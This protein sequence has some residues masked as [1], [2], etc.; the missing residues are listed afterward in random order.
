VQEI[1][2]MVHTGCLMNDSSGDNDQLVVSTTPPEL[3]TALE[4][5]GTT[6]IGPRGTVLF[7][8][9][10]KPTGVMLL[11]KGRVR[12]SLRCED[13]ELTY[14][15][16]GPGYLLGLPAIMGDRPYSLTAETLDHCVLSALDKDRMMKLLAERNDLS[17]QAV[18]M[19]ADEVARMRKHL[20]K[21]AAVS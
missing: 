1:W 18:A 16:V 21:T 12:L 15:T 2:R 3:T 10:Q 13:E 19:L 11:R 9:G 4:E 7:K 5:I 14:R 8:Q 6:V 17:L 20:A